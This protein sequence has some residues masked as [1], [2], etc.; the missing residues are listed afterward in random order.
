MTD[1]D[2]TVQTDNG[3]D[4]AQSPALRDYEA[5]ARQHGWTPQEEFKGDPDRWT[6]AETFVKRAD[7]VMPLLKKQ[8]SNLKA[9][10]DQLNRTVKRLAKAEQSAYENAIKE[11]NDRAENAVESGDIETY[12][13][14]NADLTK[15]QKEATADVDPK[16]QDAAALDAFDAFRENNTWFDK[17]ALASASEVEVEARLYADRLAEKYARQGLPNEMEPSDFFA[18]IAEETEA[19]FPL[20]KAKKTREKPPSAV[21]GVT[22]PGAGRSSK[23]GANLPPEARRQAERFFNQGIIKGKDLTDA[24]NK[25]AA[26]YDWN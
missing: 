16:A 2:T 23:T 24:L 17:G 15:L 3:P 19:R 12:R 7:E 14:V 25:Y 11:L 4:D 13:K 9:Q 22:A 6:D 10:I 21:A 8:N 5:E 1:L 26:S 20:L 18:K